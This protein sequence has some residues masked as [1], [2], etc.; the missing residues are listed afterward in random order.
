ML[1]GVYTETVSLLPFVS[2]VSADPSSTDTSYVPGNALST[3]IRAT[4]VASGT[5]NATVVANN[6][7]QFTNPSTG[8]IFQT[9]LGGLT[10]ASPLVGDPALGPINPS[11]IGLYANNSQLL[12]DRDYF[13]DAGSGIFVSTSGTTSVAPTIEN[14]AIVGNIDGVVVQDAGA[15]NP[16]TTTNVINNTFAYNTIGLIAMN[17]AATGTQQAYVANNIFWQSSSAGI[18]SQVANKLVLNNNLFS[19]N[20]PS[21]TSN[22]S[23]A[24]NIGN[25]F[26]PS[27]LGPLASNA[28][29]NL[30]NFTGYVGFVSPYDPRPTGDGPGSFF[31]DANFGLLSTSAAINNALESVA[32]KTDLL[33]NPE[34]P[35]PTTL[36]FHLAGY[37]P[38]DVGA[39]EYEPLGSTTTTA[40]GGTFRVVTTSFVPDGSSQANGNTLYVSGAPT[41]V[42]VDFSQA[43]NE[44]ISAGDG[45]APLGF[46]HQLAF[47][48][49]GD[50]YHVDRQPHG[51]L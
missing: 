22:A 51:Q 13:I 8:Q 48:G 15:S 3:I 35:N 9:E 14:D 31:L 41:S 18:Y 19:A 38:R 29:A 4:A 12:I 26:N 1:P 30:G 32:T 36:G 40:V 24:V 6:L 33:G 2:V 11:G 20:G 44:A 43:V 7:S 49:Q 25:G 50:E 17:D 42:I 16:S 5:A 37:G 23:A 47:P 39:F 10:I 34:N 28:A 21:A 46:R 45:P 27:L